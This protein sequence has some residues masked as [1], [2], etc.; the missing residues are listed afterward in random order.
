MQPTDDQLLDELRAS[1]G[2]RLRT[3]CDAF[4]LMWC[5]SENDPS[6]D[7]MDYGYTAEAKAMRNQLQRLR[8]AGKIRQQGGKWSVR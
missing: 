3:L 5:Y 4:S 2:A 6:P 7:G 1:G 8:L